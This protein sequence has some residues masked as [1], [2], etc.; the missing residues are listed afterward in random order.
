MPSILFL[1]GRLRK[2]LYVLPNVL[3][4]E[5]N[6]RTEQY[7]MTLTLV[8]DDWSAQG[9]AAACWPHQRRR[10]PSPNTHIHT[11][12]PTHPDTHRQQGMYV[13]VVWPSLTPSSLYLLWQRWRSHRRTHLLWRWWRLQ[14][15]LRWRCW[16]Y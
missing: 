1:L 13:D 3:Y 14:F 15:H 6:T 8:P 10:L 2:L 4:K 16:R 11:P 7:V 5:S 12:T 9:G